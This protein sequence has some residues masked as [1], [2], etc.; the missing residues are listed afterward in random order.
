MTPRSRNYFQR[1]KCLR[2]EI[3]LNFF[4]CVPCQALNEYGCI[5]DWLEEQN[6]IWRENDWNSGEFFDDDTL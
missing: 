1:K 4:H 6:E 3:D 5:C 2:W